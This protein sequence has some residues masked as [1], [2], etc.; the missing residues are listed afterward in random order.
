MAEYMYP[1]E[2]TSRRSDRISAIDAPLGDVQHG[3]I[4]DD[5]LAS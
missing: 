3:R 2:A 5:A 1:A 4:D